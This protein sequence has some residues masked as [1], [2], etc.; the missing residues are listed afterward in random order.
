MEEQ[1][2]NTSPSRKSSRVEQIV[3]R[4]LRR[5]RDTVSRERTSG[6]GSSSSRSNS[7]P[8][9]PLRITLEIHQ[10]VLLG[11]YGFEIS[12]QPPFIVKEVTAGGPTDGRLLPG[13]QILKLNGILVEDVS[14]QRAAEI[15]RESR[16]SLTV[17]VLRYTTGPKSSFITAEKRARL[18]TNPVK[19]RFAEEVVVNGHAQGNSLLFLPNVLKV[20]LE[21]GQTKAFKFEEKTTVKD[22]VL[23]LKEKLSIRCIEHFALV[24][25]EQYNI[26]KLYLLHDDE[27]IEQVV[28]KK[29]SHHYRCL[30]RVCFVPRD[31]LDLLQED[32]VAFEYLYLQS[33]S[34]V[35]Q[36]RFAVE[37]KCNMAL[38]LA[39]LHMQERLHSCGQP[40][41]LSLKYIAKDW[42]IENFISP[43]LLRNM[44]DKDLK[45]AISYHMKKTQALLDPRQKQLISAV[46]ARLSYLKILGELKSYGGKAFSATMMLQDRESVVTLLVGAKYGISQIVNHKLNITTTL[47]EF[48][49]ISR[50]E[51]IPESEKVS[52]VKIYLQDIKP[53]TLLLESHAAKE[54]ACLIT[55]YY[56]LF[57][58]SRVSVFSWPENTKT[59]RVSAEEGYVS[60]GCSDSEESSEIDSAQD[61][62]ADLHFPKDSDELGTAGQ[63]EQTVEAHA[64]KEEPQPEYLKGEGEQFTDR[65]RRDSEENTAENSF[66]EASDS[67]RSESRGDARFNASFSSDSM[68]ALEEDDL[69]ACSSSQPL[70]LEVHHPYLLD[71]PAQPGGEEGGGNAESSPC[72]GSLQLSRAAA[73]S[74]VDPAP[75]PSPSGASEGSEAVFDCVFTFEE[76]ARPYYNLCANVTPDSARDE[77]VPA[78]PSA[79]ARGE[80]QL[81]GR[82]QAPILQPPPGFGDTSS[83]DEFFD[84]P[85]RLTPTSAVTADNAAA[86]SSLT[87]TWSVSEIEVNVVE[88]EQEREAAP[89]SKRSRK[90]RSFVETDYTSQV[91]FPGPQDDDQLCC[92]EKELLSPHRHPSPTISSLRN[93]EGE[94]ALLETKTLVGRQPPPVAQGKKLSSNLMEME[95][96]TMETKSVTESLIMVSPIMAIRC[97]SDPEGKESYRAKDTGCDSKGGEKPLVHHMF[98]AE[99]NGEARPLGV[100]SCEGQ[101]FEDNRPM[102]EGKGDDQNIDPRAV[103]PAT[104]QAAG[105]SPVG[106]GGL[107]LALVGFRPIPQLLYTPSTEDDNQLEEEPTSFTEELCQVAPSLNTS[108]AIRKG[109]S[110]SHECLWHVELERAS[111]ETGINPRELSL[112]FGSVTSVV[113]RLSTSTLRGKIQRLPRYLSRSQEAISNT[114]TLTRGSSDAVA[115]SGICENGQ[116]L[117]DFFHDIGEAGAVC[118]ASPL[119]DLIQ[120]RTEIHSPFTHMGKM[121]DQS[122]QTHYSQTEESRGD[123]LRPCSSQQPSPCPGNLAS[124]CISGTSECI[125]LR[126]I[127]KSPVEV[128]GCQTVYANCFSGAANSFD[129]ELTVYEFSCQTQGPLTVPPSSRGFC[130]PELSPLLSPLDNELSV[131]CYLSDS[132]GDT[133]NQLRNKRYEPPWGFC[134][135]QEDISELLQVL[136]KNPESRGQHHKETCAVQFSENKQLLYAESRK[137]MSSCQQAIRVGQ[138]PEEM[139]LAVSDSFQTL[140]QLATVCLWF[141]NCVRCQKRHA[142]VLASLREIVGTYAEFVRAAEKACGRKSCQDLAIKLLARQCTALTAR[143]FCLTQLFRTLTAL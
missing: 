31:P 83:E 15:I 134:L 79:S 105:Y 122:V 49:N 26:T 103:P 19:V 60:R 45:K 44:R 75:L 126:N 37:M 36:E 67:C 38:R 10:D 71:V 111:G 24:L 52:L 40:Q 112:G 48:L 93:T 56:K 55:G 3:G 120:A 129:D 23:T 125:S 69:E 12:S 59:H 6:D 94:P 95:P 82:E 66:S 25:E 4:W 63:R 46:Q 64:Q 77:R 80:D 123:I 132:L 101:I 130:S 110:L 96:D 61:V 18:K 11:Q 73:D 121:E 100:T 117:N 27:F 131:D 84:A 68:D 143:V 42:G 13:D 54:L 86:G 41:K 128:C 5:S 139:L 124:D 78:S 102:E 142:E 113:S 14:G 104:E 116:L 1:E 34:D 33:C 30:F 47:T 119:T 97:R 108:A 9:F 136:Q 28:Q 118:L 8:N 65:S 89:L 22:I 57:V 58:D 29:E 74:L 90:R 88:R 106:S 107:T 140:V 87:R 138:S 76:D 32:P 98:L 51:L 72:I 70:L 17:T 114:V 20:Y 53:I 16:D 135:L 2:T 39:A 85:E 127:P 99:A 50:V 81:G 92:F 109:I 62:L 43:T 115:Q 35:L 91:S 7:Q 141:T 133:L 137:L 21:N